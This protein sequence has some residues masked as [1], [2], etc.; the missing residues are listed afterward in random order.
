MGGG[1]I[2]RHSSGKCRI[3]GCCVKW[4][5]SL[6]GRVREVYPCWV[7]EKTGSGEVKRTC[8]PTVT[9]EQ[10]NFVVLI[11]VLYFVSHH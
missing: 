10:N 5:R 6:R 8:D 4:L 11:T 9:T 1:D 3:V 2:N 7:I